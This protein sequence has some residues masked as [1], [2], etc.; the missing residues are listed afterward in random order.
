MYMS[1]CNLVG[2]VAATLC[3]TGGNGGLEK[4][5]N[6]LEGTRLQNLGD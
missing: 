1:T 4:L 3:Y 5:H 2:F 6:L